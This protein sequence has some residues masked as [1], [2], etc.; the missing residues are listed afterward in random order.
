[1]INQLEKAIL[2]IAT[3][4]RILDAE[5]TAEDDEGSR[6]WADE[7]SWTVKLDGDC[8]VVEVFTFDGGCS[9]QWYVP[10]TDDGDFLTELRELITKAR[11]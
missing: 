10:E 5:A 4:A 2:L 3:A 1:M 9:R 8:V 7:D 11:A 6:V